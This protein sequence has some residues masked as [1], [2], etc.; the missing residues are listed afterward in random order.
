MDEAE[1]TLFDI[2]INH[3]ASKARPYTDMG[4]MVLKYVIE[5]AA[6]CNYS[7]FVKRNIIDP[8]KLDNTFTVVPDSKIENVANTNFGVSCDR[9]GNFK[10]NFDS[11][12][13]TVHDPKARVFGQKQGNLS[14]H[15]GLFSSAKDM[16][17]LARSLI[18]GKL[19]T[20]QSLE[21]MAINRTGQK[22]AEDKYI[23]YLG[24]L[25]YSKHPQLL[26]SEVQHSLSGRAFSSAGYTGT[27]ITVDPINKVYLSFG[28]NKTH[29]RLSFIA[30]EQSKLITKDADG[31]GRVFLP[32]GREIVDS[33][34][35]VWH[36]DEFFVRPLTELALQYKMLEDLQNLGKENTKTTAKTLVLH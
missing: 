6:A 27:Q 19:I 15:A 11:P 5:G 4:A 16:A 10:I 17:V 12:L 35:F 9:E 18:E 28:S 13:G 29:N 26:N 33:R 31:R 21:E 32:S 34:D 8:L 24:Y 36:K 22:T 3:E 7:D 25:V 30:A 1:Q 23:P 2:E 14:G 20:D